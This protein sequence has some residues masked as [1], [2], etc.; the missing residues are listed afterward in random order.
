MELASRDAPARGLRRY[1]WLV[2]DALR[3]SE[4][5]YD[6]QLGPPAGLYFALQRRLGGFPERDL[7]LVW[8]ERDGWS[9]AIEVL[10]LS[11]LIPLTYLGHDILPAP[12]VVATFVGSLFAGEQ[13]GQADPP[14][15]R[16]PGTDDELPERLAAYDPDSERRHR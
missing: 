8:D 11:D 6:V 12:R 15:L 3:L 16:A 4:Q 2:A 13:P 5:D 10:N 7:A 14:A 1:A 9:A